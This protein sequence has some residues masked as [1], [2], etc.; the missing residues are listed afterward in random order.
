MAWLL[1]NLASAIV[2]DVL[3]EFA[4]SEYDVSRFLLERGANLAVVSGFLGDI[5]LLTEHVRLLMRLHRARQDI[6]RVEEVREVVQEVLRGQKIAIEDSS[7]DNSVDLLMENLV[8]AVR[9]LLKEELKRNRIYV[10]DEADAVLSRGVPAAPGFGIGVPVIWKNEHIQLTTPFVLLIGNV[11]MSS[12]VDPRP[13]IEQSAAVITWDGG[14]TSHIAVGCRLIHRAAV[15]VSAPE[16]DMLRRK[17]FLVVDGSSGMV[18]SY[19]RP[20]QVEGGSTETSK[21]EAGAI[22]ERYKKRTKLQRDRAGR[23]RA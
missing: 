22:A 19:H 16:A 23:G 12:K 1:I 13:A 4:A 21:N 8:P 15:I 6:R 20:P 5:Q 3:K 17:R 2:Y 7:A 14:M 9:G 10:A 11:D 18:R